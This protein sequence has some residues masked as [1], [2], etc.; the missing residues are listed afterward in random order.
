M[1]EE[2]RKSCPEANE[3][4]NVITS[5]PTFGATRRGATSTSTRPVTVNTAPP[6]KSPVDALRANLES[7]PERLKT[8]VTDLRAIEEVAPRSSQPSFHAVE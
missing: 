2:K 8:V 5:P 3:P 7:V 1:Y 4:Q 6:M